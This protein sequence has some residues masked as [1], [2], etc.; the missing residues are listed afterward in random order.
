MNKIVLTISAVMAFPVYAD[1]ICSTK[2]FSS[3]EGQGSLFVAVSVSGK[4][5]Y[6]YQHGGEDVEKFKFGFIDSTEES[7]FI[8]AEYGTGRRSPHGLTLPSTVTNRFSSNKEF[9][10]QVIPGDATVF[11]LDI[12]NG[13]TQGECND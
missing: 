10:I 12:I 8:K 2:L 7:S 13:K 11:N 4:K 6:F 9:I 3:V 1:P 5:V